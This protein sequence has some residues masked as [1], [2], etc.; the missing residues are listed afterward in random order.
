MNPENFA[1]WL[2]WQDYQVVRTASSYWYEASSRVFQA[3]PYH[4]LIQPAEDEIS[5]LLRQENAIALRYSTPL[6]AGQGCISY[7]AVYDA[8]TYKIEDLDRRSRQNIRRGLRSCSVEQIPI[9]RLA[10][11]GWQLE[12]DTQQRQGSQVGQDK[13]AWRQRYLAAADLPGFEAWGA[14][15]EGKLT[16]SLL[17]CQVDDCCTMISQQCLREYLNAR[18]NNALTFVVTETM[19]NRPGITSIFYALHSLDAPASV[20]EFKFRMGY[21]AK[22]VRQRV[23]FHPWLDPLVNGYLHKAS[24]GLT[25]RYPSRRSLAKVEGMLR[26]HLQGKQDLVNQDW[27]E[28]LIDQKN[29]LL[30]DI[31]MEGQQAGSQ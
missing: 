29:E 31:S 8:D 17:T 27:P 2:R 23:V 9:E 24:L 22:A 15:V 3:F 20:D 13:E 5:G 30:Q 6:N 10:E 14:L 16:A 1:E 25:R 18:V 26:F 11:E 12:L 4:W 21:R 7:H 28:N 19:V